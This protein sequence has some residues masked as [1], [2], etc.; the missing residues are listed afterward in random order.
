[1][2]TVVE[3][4]V[5]WLGRLGAEFLD[6]SAGDVFSRASS[7]FWYPGDLVI[8]EPDGGDNL[9]FFAGGG[10]EAKGSSRLTVLSKSSDMK[11]KSSEVFDAFV[12]F[13]VVVKLDLGFVEVLEEG[14]GAGLGGGKKLSTSMLL[15]DRVKISSFCRFG[16]S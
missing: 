10:S 16:A 1:L 6:G 7:H 9:G 3:V 11:K 13:E 15:S 5:L 14:L 12:A 4:E 8:L 2:G